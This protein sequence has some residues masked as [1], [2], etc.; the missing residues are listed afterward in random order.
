[1][2]QL[3]MTIGVMDTVGIFSLTCVSESVKQDL[4]KEEVLSADD[5]DHLPGLDEL[6]SEFCFNFDHFCAC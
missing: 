2:L 6:L 5:T 1:V 3:L 4:P